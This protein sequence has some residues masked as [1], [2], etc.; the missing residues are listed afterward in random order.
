MVNEVGRQGVWDHGNGLR[1][2]VSSA[3][4]CV[5]ACVRARCIEMPLTRVDF[6]QL[7]IDDGRNKHYRG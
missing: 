4:M 5:R 7:V 2:V 1:N 3:A 6:A